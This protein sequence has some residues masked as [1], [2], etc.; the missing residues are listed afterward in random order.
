M[1]KMENFAQTREMRE[2]IAAARGECARYFWKS[3]ASALRT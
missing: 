1:H 2:R 3:I